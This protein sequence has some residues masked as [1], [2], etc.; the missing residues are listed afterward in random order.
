MDNLFKVEPVAA[1]AN[2]QQLVWLAMHQCYSEEM[3]FEA[4]A[5][6][7]PED[8]AGELVVKHLLQGGRG[9]YGPLE[10][11]AININAGYFPHSTM[12]QLRTHRSGFTFDVQSFRYT[13]KRVCDLAKKIK[14]AIAKDD[15]WEDALVKGQNEP[16]AKSVEE[17]F[18]LRPTG[19][20][21]DRQGK[22]YTYSRLRRGLHLLD[23]AKASLEYASMIADGFSEEHARSILPFDIR[24]HFMLGLN[25][26]SLMHLL[27]LRWKADAQ[28]ECQ[29]FS[30]LL[31]DQFKAWAPEIAQWYYKD[32]AKKAKL[33]P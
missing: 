5:N 30:E 13:G 9:H 14:E 18:Y 6:I 20:Y 32:R 7:P 24:Q 1:I 27:D 12:Q 17:V 29:Q 22:K 31:F 10:Q 33:S 8:K 25:M 28:L 16:L 15:E 21:R 23:T 11:A 19:E 3:V 2:P 4:M 26:R